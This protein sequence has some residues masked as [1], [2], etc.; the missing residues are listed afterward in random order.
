MWVSGGLSVGV[1][2]KG[3]CVEV[4]NIDRMNTGE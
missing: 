4:D 3:E 2:I 1:G